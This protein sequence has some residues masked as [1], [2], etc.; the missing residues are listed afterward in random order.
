MIDDSPRQPWKELEEIVTADDARQLEDYLH[1]LAPAEIAQ[2]I[3][4]LSSASQTGLLTMLNPG[5]AASVIEEV[6]EVQAANL[7]EELPADQA[8]A[9][10]DEMPSDQQVDLLGDL[11]E[12]DSEAILEEMS[13]EKA[14]EIRQL[15]SYP[16]D[17]AGG[18]M[19]TEYLS[20]PDHL[21][22]VN[23]LDDLREHGERYSDY[24]VQYAYVTS[25][26]STLVGVLRLRDLF[27]SPRNRSLIE[28]MIADP[29]TVRDDAPLDELRQF[30]DQH[31]F[32]G[33][34]VT[35]GEGR[36]VGVVQRA[37]VDQATEKE[38]D[39]VFLESSGIVG[40]EELRS[41]KLFS[42]SS[43]RLSW[44]SVNIIL[45]IIAASVI[46]YYQETLAAAIILAVFLPMISDMSGC[47]GNQAA[48]VSIRELTLGLVK[49]REL[50]RVLLK[51]ASLGMIN[52]L[53]LGSLLG[54]VAW[55]WQGNPYLGLVVGGALALN[56]LI[57]V[58]IGGL[59]PLVLRGL[60]KDPALASGPILTT[61]TDMCGFFL[62]LS[63]ASAVLPRLSG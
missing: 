34:P 56:T 60:K 58:A 45:N 43:R 47:S 6:T 8:A 42:R 51:E 25:A 62:V 3:S 55:L 54:G 27:L 22:V 30:F 36:L 38:A 49:P 7:I 24:H 61:V 32:L 13:S 37:A 14:E 31:H 63:F 44:L 12:A 11:A 17:T 4:R 21:Q 20:Y 10:V 50:G 15:L 18:I 57:A 33:V 1:T 46:A 48:A 23:V 16:V 53:I 35:D 19:A 39:K 2:A 59:I 5:E 9:I 29:L 41:M 26:T 40:G 52:G 28:M